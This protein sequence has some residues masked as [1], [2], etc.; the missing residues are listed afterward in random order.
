[1]RCISPLSDI[2]VE[3]GVDGIDADQAELRGTCLQITIGR[4]EVDIRNIDSDVVAC[5]AFPSGGQCFH[6]IYQ[7]EQFFLQEILVF[8]RNEVDAAKV[9]DVRDQVTENHI[10]PDVVYGMDAGYHLGI[11]LLFVYHI[12]RNIQFIKMLASF[13]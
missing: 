7:Y 10:V 9:L 1:M 11:L 3:N 2:R 5:F 13:E 12:L 6:F 4:F 8:I